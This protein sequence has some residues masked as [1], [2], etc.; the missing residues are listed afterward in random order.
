MR[1]LGGKY[2]IRKKVARIIESYHVD[3]DQYVVEPFC[4]GCWVTQEIQ[5]K[6][7]IAS[8]FNHEI[9]SLY[10]ALQNGWR[11]KE[12]NKEEWLKVKNTPDDFKYYEV[13]F[14]ACAYS[15]G[16]IW[17]NGYYSTGG[18]QAANCVKQSAKL[19][20]IKFTS[21]SYDR[22][23]YPSESL[24]YCDPPYEDTKGYS[25]GEFD[26]FKFW[27]WCRLMTRKGHRVLISE[28]KA[29][30]D[31]ELVASFPK[32]KMLRQQDKANNE[33]VSDNL[34]TYSLKKGSSKKL[35]EK[36]LASISSSIDLS[37]KKQLSLFW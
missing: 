23:H 4:G 16:A 35:K 24:I 22:I 12:L 28:Y 14:A 8:D 25:T 6:N 15:F 2:S 11:P 26:N 19:K 10:I 3:I 30:S 17:F 1:Y 29:P 32:R 21:G 7:I 34:Y 27:D 9:V 36:E 5:A 33:K 18:N 37:R 31:F 13:A 20:H